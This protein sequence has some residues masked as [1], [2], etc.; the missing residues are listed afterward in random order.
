MKTIKFLTVAGETYALGHI[1]DTKVGDGSWSAKKLIDTLCPGFSVTGQMVTC[2]PLEGYPL[3]VISQI[4]PTQGGSGT[5]S[6]ANIRPITGLAELSLN[7][8]GKNLLSEDWKY[9]KNYSYDQNLVLSL[10]KGKYVLSAEKKDVSYL[11]LQR[12]LNGGETRETYAKLHTS[13][14]NTAHS[15]AFEVTGAD[16]EMWM[17]WTS[18]QKY[19]DAIKWMQIEAGEKATAFEP[20]AGKTLRASLGQT[21][22]GGAYNW[23]TGELTLTHG[24]YAMTG[25]E[26]YRIDGTTFVAN[27]TVAFGEGCLCS[28]GQIGAWDTADNGVRYTPNGAYS[29]NA[30]GLESFRAYVAAQYANGTPVQ[31]CYKLPAPI[32]VE[33][34]PNEIY[35]DP[36][37]NTFSAL[38]ELTVSGKWD[39]KQ[40]LEGVIQ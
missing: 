16:G 35:A 2:Q 25:Q 30:S 9:F 21:V 28:H 10:P 31:L 20:Y 27:T 13:S 22:Y 39:F 11:Y 38:Q 24:C 1:D 33:I 3:A 19:L 23:K 12:S 17:L 34:T 6:T 18:A 36:G 8:C 40:L 32:T 15:V 5:P 14:S 29:L 7:H 37:K 26:Q 4:T